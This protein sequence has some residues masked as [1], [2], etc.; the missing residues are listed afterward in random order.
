MKITGDSSFTPTSLK[1]NTNLLVYDSYHS[2]K[3]KV[4]QSNPTP[5]YSETVS[6]QNLAP[7]PPTLPLAITPQNLPRTPP[8]YQKHLYHPSTTSKNFSVKKNKNHSTQ[9]SRVVPHRGTN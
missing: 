1:I 7:H 8:V 4:S 6:S 9:D 5:A 2:E 3:G